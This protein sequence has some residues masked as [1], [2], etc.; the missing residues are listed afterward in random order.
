[1][2]TGVGGRRLLPK[3]SRVLLLEETAAL[4]RGSPEQPQTR[5]SVPSFGETWIIAMS[6]GKALHTNSC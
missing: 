3:T 6:N 4:W 1:M 5:M 2:G